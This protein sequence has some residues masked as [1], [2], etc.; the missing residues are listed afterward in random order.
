MKIPHSEQLVLS[1][2]IDDEV[3]DFAVNLIRINSSYPPGDTRTIAKICYDKLS[4]SSIT[5]RLLSPPSNIKSA[6]G[7]RFN[8]S[9]YQSVVA[10]IGKKG[11]VLTLHSHLDTVS[12]GDINRWDV[13][14]YSGK[15]IADV[16]YG[17]GAGDDKGSVVAQVMALVAIKKSGIPLK[18][19][20]QLVLAADEEASS[21]RG[22]RW[23]LDSGVI[24]PDILIIG[25][26]TNNSICI[27]ERA[28]LWL[29]IKIIGR[30]AHGAMPWEGNNAVIHMC[31]FVNRVNQEVVPK[32][33]TGKNNSSP[34]TTISTTKIHGGEKTNI[35]PE[36]CVLD[37]DCRLA[38]ANHKGSVIECL[39]KILND[40]SHGH[41]KFEYSIEVLQSDGM[42]IQTD[43]S[44][45]IVEVMSE[46]LHDLT[47]KSSKL[48][49]YKQASDGRLF[50]DMG[51]P[52]LIFG[53]GDPALG[54]SPNEFVSINQ[55]IQAT[56]VIAL[57]SVR[58]LA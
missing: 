17:R 37:L 55:L 45:Q 13:N 51:M 20:L 14:P 40:D 38:S 41:K 24:H 53:P 49:W 25:E 52:I 29:R 33:L 36:E 46:V 58:M 4:D 3:I 10:E 54:H 27:A 34:F 50:S 32:F 48:S 19:T 9:L 30:S 16:I 5:A 56:K 1:Q 47:G 21:N 18:G 12:P 6:V 35:I 43:P 26:Q 15:I 31:N 44:S 11:K 28:V 7:D 22:T 23:L 2:V 39:E 8:N 42:P 57:T